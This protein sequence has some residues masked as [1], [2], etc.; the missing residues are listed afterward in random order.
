MATHFI[1]P[2]RNPGGKPMKSIARLLLIASLALPFAACKKEEAPKEAV[3]APLAAPT[4][5]D[6][7]AWMAYLQ[8]VV[9]RN[10]DGISQSPFVYMVPS[11]NTPDFQEKYDSLSE[12]AKSD[13]SRGIVEGNL[14]AYG[15]YSSAK[16]ADMVVAAFKDVQP[17]T[18]KGVK[19]LFIGKAEDSP[20]VQAAVA[21]AGVNYVFV[22]AK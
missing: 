13:V 1:N 14:L 10:M 8:D 2:F 20:R 15:G 12:K 18:M 21:P 17:N 5:D 7:Q 6:R 4:T 19:V 3:K 9:T 11:E 16:V 22:E